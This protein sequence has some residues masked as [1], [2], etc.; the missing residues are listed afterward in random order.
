LPLSSHPP[1]F[2][3]LLRPSL[4]PLL[5]FMS[6]RQSRWGDPFF[7]PV[8]LSHYSFALTLH[9]KRPFFPPASSPCPGKVFGSA[10]FGFGRSTAISFFLPFLPRPTLMSPLSQASVL[11]TLFSPSPCTQWSTDF[12]KA[13]ASYLALLRSFDLFIFPRFPDSGIL[14]FSSVLVYLK[15]TPTSILESPSPPQKR[16]LRQPFLNIVKRVRFFLRQDLHQGDGFL[17]S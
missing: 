12:A 14:L 7:R 17:S 3:P 6:S 8:L 2:P 5:S 15:T 11:L 4:N 1:I 9:L 13:S 16:T 10:V